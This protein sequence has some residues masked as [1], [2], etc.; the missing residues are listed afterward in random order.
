LPIVDRSRITDAQGRRIPVTRTT[1]PGRGKLETVAM[2]A[3]RSA[4]DLRR[5]LDELASRVRRLAPP[6]TKR[7][8]RFH[9]GRSEI[10]RELQKLAEALKD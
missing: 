3:P 2:G 4:R 5:R 7:P 10:A 6:E 8:E 9:E 1:I